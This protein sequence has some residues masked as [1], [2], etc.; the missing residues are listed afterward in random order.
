MEKRREIPAKKPMAAANG[1]VLALKARIERLG[2]DFHDAVE[3]AG[4]SRPQGYRLL[5]GE[6][7]IKMLRN[8]D[9]WTRKQ[10]MAKKIPTPQETQSQIDEW[11]ALGRDLAE[12]DPEEFGRTLDGLRDLLAA[13]KLQLAAIR[14]M[15]RANPEE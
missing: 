2:I 9:E 6:A 14:K 11:T 8:L 12:L 1:D 13:K 10:E 15:F 5:N 7:S 4:Y 3:K